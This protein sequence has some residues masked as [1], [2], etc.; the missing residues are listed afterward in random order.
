MNKSLCC[1][2]LMALTTI[3]ASAQSGTNSPYSQFGLGDLASQTV[4]QNKGMGGVGYAF[5]K[6]NEVNPMNPASYSS[7]DSL[8]FIFDAGVSGQLTQFREK[9]EEVTGKSGGFDYVVGSFRLVKHVGITFGILPYSNIGYNYHSREVLQDVDAIVRTTHTG[10][11]GLNQVFLGAG[12]QIAKPLSIGFNFSYLWGTNERSVATSST[13]DVNTLTK[14][15][16]TSVNNYK[17]DLGLQLSLP[18][19]KK[20]MMTLGAVV[21]PGHNTKADPECIITNRKSTTG[22]RDSLRY[23]LDDAIELP[24]SYGVGLAYQHGST[25][26]MGVDYQLQQWGKIMMPEFIDENGE[27]RYELK[28]G[29]LKD[30]HRVNVGAEWTPNANSMKFFKRIR[31]RIGGGY[32]TPYYY[33]NGGEGPKEYHASL[34]F[35]IP[36]MN[37]Y[38]HRSIL[39]ISAEWCRRSAANLVKENTFR[40]NIGLTFNERWFAKWKVD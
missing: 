8:T 24:W 25:F 26:R 32:A 38:N 27:G 15:Y 18:L 14:T 9:Q 35:G 39:N 17:L 5:R 36:I 23:T 3:G 7:I 21:S 1:L 34:G 37:N 6:G 16:R 22:E 20:D 33:I 31:Y 11:G 19:G 29:L 28:S 13:S 40:I 12:W 30:L 2:A 10:S 4:G